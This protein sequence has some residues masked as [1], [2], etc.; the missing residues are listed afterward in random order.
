MTVFEEK[1]QTQ[2]KEKEKKQLKEKREKTLGEYKKIMLDLYKYKDTNIN[3]DAIRD[4][5]VFIIGPVSYWHPSSSLTP[6]LI[7]HLIDVTVAHIHKE[8]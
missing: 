2:L 4:Q 1:D 6:F 8:T 7:F 3:I 5:N